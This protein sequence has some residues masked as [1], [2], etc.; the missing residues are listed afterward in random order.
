MIIRNHNMNNI[1]DIVHIVVSNNHLYVQRNLLT[2]LKGSKMANI[3]SQDLTEFELVRN[4]RAFKLLLEFLR[5][6]G[7]INSQRFS[8]N[9][10]EMLLNELN[11]WGI[12]QSVYAT[13]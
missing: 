4:P 12:S 8:Q 11:Y 13:L 1:D 5:L 3:F 2:C 6:N 7:Q 10:L 9:D